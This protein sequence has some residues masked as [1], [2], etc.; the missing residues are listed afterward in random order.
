MPGTLLRLPIYERTQAA[1]ARRLTSEMAKSLGF[2]EELVG[3]VA[4]IATEAAMNLVNHAR[5][6]ELL[7]SALDLNAIEIVAVDRGPGMNVQ[8]C[9]E[10]GYSTAGTSGTGLGAIRRLSKSFDV[11]SDDSGTVLLS[12]IERQPSRVPGIQVGGVCVPI[13][14]ETE[15]GDNFACRD[16]GNVKA[17]LIAD[18]L[19]HG[20]FAAEAARH[21][22]NAFHELEW[23]GAADAVDYLHGALRGTRGAAIAVAALDASQRKIFY[24]GLGNTSGVILSS[25]R[26]QSMISHN[27]T[28]GHN[29]SRIAEFQYA[30]PEESTVVLHTDGL[31]TS[32]SVT[33]YPGLLMRH[34]SVVSGVLYRDYARGRDDCT[35]IAAM[36]ARQ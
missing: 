34:P 30:W 36:E 12:R 10:D 25:G 6:G 11:W 29:A 18:G 13:A 2:S 26:S 23:R 31:A 19:G 16:V 14:G 24:S 7:V 20:P 27:G 8:R 15:S 5:D 1:E 17:I 4:I 33:R 32:W 35:V 9:L 3:Q 21:A 28:A 22:I